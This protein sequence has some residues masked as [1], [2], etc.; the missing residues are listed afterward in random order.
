MNNKTDLIT[1][2]RFSNFWLIAGLLTI[3]LIVILSRDITRPFTGLHSWAGAGGSTVARAHVKYGLGFTKG[4]STWAYGDPPTENP[5]VYLDHPQLNNLIVA[6]FMKVFGLHDWTHR[7]INLVATAM[8]LLLFLRL[9]REFTDDVTTLLAGLL[10]TLFPLIGYFG[11]GGWL[12]VFVYWA[13]W[14]YFT[15]VGTINKDCG[16]LLKYKIGLA[17]AIFLMV[18]ISWSGFFFAF[19]IGLHYVCGCLFRRQLPKGD[20]L[21]ILVLAPFA[22]L[23]LTFAIMAAGYHWDISKMYHLFLW[24][25]EK[26]EMQEF[27]WSAW[28]A[29]FWEFAITNFT[30]PIL[31]S[32][33]G[34]FTIG[35]LFVFMAP[36]SKEKIS[37]FGLRRFPQFWIFLMPGLTQLL[38]FRGNI[39][40]HQTWE[41]PLSQLIAIAAALGILLLGD[42][43]RKA[44]KKLAFVVI[45]III[46]ITVGLTISGTNHYYG[47][48]W[49]NENK[50][51]MFK[52]LNSLIPPNKDLLSYESLIVNQHESKGGFYRP[53]YGW[54]LDRDI[55]ESTSF[56]DVQRFAGTGNYPYYLVPAV[57]QLQQLISQLQANYKMA[58]YYPA[59]PSEMKNGKF[60]RAGMK[61][62]MVFDLQQ[63]LSK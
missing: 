43:V 1:E 51:R 10:Y 56:A 40:K 58:Q 35:Q 38:V 21:A 13:F 16:R 7:I 50:I 25:A 34:Y 57:P 60:Y 6:A 5:T 36:K 49:Q 15:L 42:I 55:Q 28:F 29:K 61:P 47:I 31:M 48:R 44:N 2:N 33:I 8:T 45:I 4:Y 9:L 54:Y 3:L 32:A 19:A 14:C 37:E 11:G 62:Y 63:K 22:S 20:L 46:G 53:E 59:Q 24:R 41:L 30:L 26:G 39:W 17:A 23:F 52:E 12:Y 27:L 18:A